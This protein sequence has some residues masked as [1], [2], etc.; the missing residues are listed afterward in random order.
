M[1]SQEERARLVAAYKDEPV[2]VAAVILKCSTC[3]LIIAGLAVIGAGRDSSGDDA[4]RVQQAQGHVNV[5]V[6]PGRP[7]LQEPR[8]HLGARGAGINPSAVNASCG[9]GC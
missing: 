2:Y 7:R 8:A 6:T 4:A 3:L 5:S 9:S 1:V